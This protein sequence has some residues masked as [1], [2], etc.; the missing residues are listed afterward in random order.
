M[1]RKSGSRF[2]EKDMRDLMRSFGV[3]PVCEKMEASGLPVERWS[4]QQ[5]ASAAAT[6]ELR[7]NARLMASIWLRN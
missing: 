4:S 2:C 5:S 1:S 7:R 6:E 3:E